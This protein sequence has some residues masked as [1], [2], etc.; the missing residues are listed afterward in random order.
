MLYVTVPNLHNTHGGTWDISLYCDY[1]SGAR[2]PAGFDG[3]PVPITCRLSICLSVG[4]PAYYTLEIG[5][6]EPNKIKYNQKNIGNFC[7]CN[8]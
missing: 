2:A 4:I 5:N 7:K 1:K 3:S 6:A 8:E